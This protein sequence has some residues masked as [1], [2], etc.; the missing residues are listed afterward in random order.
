MAENRSI[1]QFKKFQLSHGNPGLKISTEACLFGA[2]ASD[3]ANGTILDIGTGCGLLACMLAQKAE[4]SK[5]K[6]I[7]IHPDVAI[8]AKENIQNSPFSNQINV[9]NI[10]LKELQHNT[11]FDFIICNPPFFSNHLASQN[12][13]KQIAIHDDLLSTEQLADA[14]KNHLKET[15]KAMVLYPPLIMHHFDFCLK[16]KNLYINHIINIHP[17]LN[18]PILRQIA[19][20]SSSQTEKTMEKWE[21]KNEQNEY[22]E[23]FKTVLQPYY[24][25]FP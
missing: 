3:Y 18:S 17:K 12:E 5:I 19:L 13:S 10:D 4:H 1:F 15:G 8:L 23:K 16:N 6:A 24:L 22:S 21:I 9:I 20:I 14:I 7:E 25:I 11:L 2:I